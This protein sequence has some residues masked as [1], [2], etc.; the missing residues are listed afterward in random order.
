M[1]R[2]LVTGFGPFPR[3]PDNPS[4]R[5]ARRLAA[6]PRLRLVLAGAGGDPA[7]A[8]LAATLRAAF[9]DGAS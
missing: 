4:A 7:A 1:S 5:V 3:V 8:H 9:A 6:L 2:L